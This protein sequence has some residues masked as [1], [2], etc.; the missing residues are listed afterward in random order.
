M[1]VQ[2]D[3][4]I[5]KNDNIQKNDSHCIIENSCTMVETFL[6]LNH[7]VSFF[8]LYIYIYFFFGWFQSAF[9]CG[10]VVCFVTKT[11]VFF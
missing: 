7:F 9:I 11:L 3:E 4:M 10:G 2:M 5:K 1:V 6:S 8:N